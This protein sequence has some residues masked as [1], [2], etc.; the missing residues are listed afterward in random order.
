[1]KTLGCGVCGVAL[2]LMVVA[3]VLAGGGTGQGEVK[4]LPP[5]HK[6]GGLALEEA[7]AERRSVRA[8]LDEP[9]THEEVGQLCWAGQGITDP[10]G[11]FRAAPSAGA[12]YPLELYVVSAGGVDHYEPQK[13]RLKRHRSG[14]RRGAVQEAALHQDS[15]G[16]APACFVIAAV[17]ERT[18]RK[19][20]P[21]AERYCFIEAGHVAQNLLLQATSLGLG[22]VPVGAFSDKKVARALDLPQGQRV[23]YLVPMGRPR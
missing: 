10:R 20:G 3:G 18:A 6:A 14:D 21:R 12:L 2:V 4:A 8:F 19:Y 7:I 17:V 1:M 11:H 13:H 15:V 22:G 9:L 5:P 16:Q 23:L